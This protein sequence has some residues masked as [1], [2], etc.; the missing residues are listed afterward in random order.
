MELWNVGLGSQNSKYSDTPFHL[1]SA[2]DLFEPKNGV[3]N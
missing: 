2:L 1:Q 3:V